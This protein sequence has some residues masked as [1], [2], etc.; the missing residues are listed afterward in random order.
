MIQFDMESLARDLA[1]EIQLGGDRFGPDDLYQMIDGIG[2][3]DLETFRSRVM[4]H[5]KDFAGGSLHDNESFVRRQVDM[6]L[7]DIRTAESLGKKPTAMYTGIDLADDKGKYFLFWDGSMRKCESA[8]VT[9]AWGADVKGKI[10]SSLT[11]LEVAER[12]FD[13]LDQDEKLFI[14]YSAFPEARIVSIG[15]KGDARFFN[16]EDGTMMSL[17]D[18]MER[19]PSVVM[20]LLEAETEERLFRKLMV[21]SQKRQDVLEFRLTCHELI[22]LAGERVKRDFLYDQVVVRSNELGSV[23]V[24]RDVDDLS[25]PRERRISVL[26]DNGSIRNLMPVTEDFDAGLLVKLSS[27]VSFRLNELRNGNGL[28]FDLGRIDFMDGPVV[29]MQ[30]VDWDGRCFTKMKVDSLQPDETGQVVAVGRCVGSDGNLAG[31]V[32]CPLSKISDK[33]V[34]KIREATNGVVNFMRGPGENKEVAVKKTER[35]SSKKG[36]GI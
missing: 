27:A 31:A 1:F 12:Y 22:D 33:G 25:E 6:W 35:K 13:M 15:R 24:C 8:T 21:E 29:N 18:A 30:Y 2:A 10:V 20:G 11:P 36:V 23:T 17:V 7:A 16:L 3:D 19:Y 26:V 5:A 28:L 34:W 4:L 9:A 14:S 32:S